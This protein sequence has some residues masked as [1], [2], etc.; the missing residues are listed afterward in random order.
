M[1]DAEGSVAAFEGTEAGGSTAAALSGDGSNA[2]V[3]GA[4]AGGAAAVEAAD[5]VGWEAA[6]SG[7]GRRAVNEAGPESCFP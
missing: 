7:E 1:G 2:A 4:D 3:D 5:A 6:L